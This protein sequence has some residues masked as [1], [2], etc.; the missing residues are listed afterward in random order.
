MDDPVTA[1]PLGRYSD[2]A[3]ALTAL[4]LVGAAVVAH[5]GLI[6]VPD[7]VWL[8]T[9]AGLAVGVV[10]GQRQTTNGAGRIAQAAHRRL[11]Q[12]HAPAADEPPA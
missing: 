11:D 10:L 4:G 8:D 3:A 9:S 12:I 5:L 7:T 2:A 1:S 6:A